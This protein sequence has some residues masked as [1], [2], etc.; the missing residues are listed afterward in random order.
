MA[1]APEVEDVNQSTDPA[2][3]GDGLARAVQSELWREPRHEQ[4]GMKGT[5]VV[6]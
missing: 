2:L 1:V 3:D 6:Q 4:A 5:L